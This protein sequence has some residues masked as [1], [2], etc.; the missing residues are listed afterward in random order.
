LTAGFGQH[1]MHLMLD[2]FTTWLKGEASG[3]EAFEKTPVS[4]FVMGGGGGEKNSAGK[5]VH[6]GQWRHVS[7]W[8]QFPEVAMELRSGGVLAEAGASVGEGAYTE[9][10]YDP[11]NPTP[12]IASAVSS[13][14]ELL[15]W[16][17][18]GIARPTPDVLKQSLIIQGAAN[19][20][21]RE[22]MGHPAPHGTPL[23]ER[24]D[25]L[26]FVSEPLTSPIEVTGQ[27]SAR[28]FLSS[29][30]PDTDLHVMLLDIYPET[31]QWPGGYYLNLVD[32]LQRVRYRNGEHAPSLLQA[33]EI[34]EVNVPVG[35][36]SN[37]FDVGHRIGIW[38]SSSA[39]PRFDPNPNTGE[40][41][42]QHTHTRVARNRIH[43]SR[44]YPSALLLPTN[45]GR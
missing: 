35:P 8:P 21:T 32:G 39:F 42:G 20:V 30:A 24:E 17:A 43:H 5:L 37:N 27:V 14:H 19:Q 13:H 29:D 16:P 15:P 9:Y 3:W 11:E 7:Q 45:T 31:E 28:L 1:R 25:V 18:R 44:D 4:Y 2:F 22:D 26:A 33:G 10:T 38:I 40:P 36:I 6:G 12:S 41:I 34:V 23:S